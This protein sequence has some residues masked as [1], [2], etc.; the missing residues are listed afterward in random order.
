VATL[1]LVLKG[2]TRAK[3][4]KKFKRCVRKVKKKGT[5]RNPHAVCG[6]LKKGHKEKKRG[7]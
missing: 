1:S 2:I 6:K 3:M 5:A 7:G 4:P